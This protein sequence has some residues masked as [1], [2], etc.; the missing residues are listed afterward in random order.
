MKD[1]DFS[2]GNI[3]IGSCY[4]VLFD[5]RPCFV[6]I[7]RRIAP[8][9]QG[10]QGPTKWIGERVGEVDN[11][12]KEGQS[13][14]LIIDNFIGLPTRR[15]MCVQALRLGLKRDQDIYNWLKQCGVPT[16]IKTVAS[17]KWQCLNGPFAKVKSNHNRGNV[18]ISQATRELAPV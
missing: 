17:Y 15:E 6:K 18:S 5:G 2:E 9:A 11:P 16:N 3:T 4:S 14:T 13:V 7:I 1:Y 12:E 10:I 8:N